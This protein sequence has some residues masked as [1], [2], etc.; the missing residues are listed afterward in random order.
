MLKPSHDPF[1]PSKADPIDRLPFVK[2]TNAGREFWSVESTGDYRQ[3]CNLG[4]EYALLALEFDAGPDTLYRGHFIN[5][6]L[7][8]MGRDE[9]LR[10]IESAFRSFVSTAAATADLQMLRDYHKKRQELLA[11]MQAGNDL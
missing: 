6:V 9:R 4:E 7:S 10:A 5:Q 1:S 11:T 2:L 3:D 8:V